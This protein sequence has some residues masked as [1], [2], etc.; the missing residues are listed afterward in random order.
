M[1]HLRAHLPTKRNL[2]KTSLSFL[3]AIVVLTLLPAGAGAKLPGI[4]GFPRYHPQTRCNPKPKPGT[5][6]LANYLMRHYRGSGSLGIS[7]SCGAS[8]TSEHK[9][10]RAFDWALNASSRRDRRYAAN[11]LHRLRKADRGGRKAALA[12]RMGVMYVIWND[13]IYSATY[14]YRKQRYKNVG[15]RRIRGCSASL[16][17]RN[18]MHISLT[19]AAAAGHTSWYE[20]H[21]AAKT[22]HK[23]RHKAKRK[24][25]H[26]VTP[27]VRH[28]RLHRKH[29]V[30]HRRHR[31]AH[32]AEHRRHLAAHKRQHRADRAAHRRHHRQHSAAHRRFHQRRHSARDHRRFH[33]KAARHHRHD[34]RKAARH[35]KREHRHAA[36]HH[37]R[38][39]RA[40]RR[41]HRRDH[42][43]RRYHRRTVHRHHRRRHSARL[44]APNTATQ[45]DPTRPYDDQQLVDVDGSMRG[46]RTVTDSSEDALGDPPTPRTTTRAR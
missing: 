46:W 42:Q 34:H 31:T 22:P 20:H 15:C 37:R 25:K 8:G 5:V 6:E 28:K 26:K 14:H 1:H 18:H 41:H 45:V 13:R 11:F 10:G 29:S 30:H 43:V 39:H 17:H 9:E 12:R 2:F 21:R 27:K 40:A 36:R 7:R 33:G 38:D 4:E 16:R 24:P 23:V 32:K 44:L 19:R 3:A 35:H